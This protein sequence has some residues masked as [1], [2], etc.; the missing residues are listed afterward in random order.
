[1]SHGR[2][3]EASGSY[4]SKVPT[5]AIRG[6]QLVAAFPAF[7]APVAFGTSPF[8][9][10]QS[11]NGDLQPL[12]AVDLGFGDLSSREYHQFDLQPD[13]LLEPMTAL[14]ADLTPL[15]NFFL[16]RFMLGRGG[17]ETPGT[18]TVAEPG[19][20]ALFALPAALIILLRRRQGGCSI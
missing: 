14:E 6:K 8:S 12:A 5:A 16:P 20:A 7:T 19:N 17:R 2:T 13:Y 18:E 4:V 11:S 10:A 3:A 1:M 9:I 15:L